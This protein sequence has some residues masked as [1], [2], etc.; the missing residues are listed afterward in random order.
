[1]DSSATSRGGADAMLPGPG[2]T[3]VGKYRVDAVIGQ[4]GMGIVMGG[5]D[6]S[7]GRPVAI[8]FLSPERA[9]RPGAAERFL[10]EARSAAM[11]QSEHV[12]RV[13]EVS[14]LPNGAPFIV[15]EHLRGVDLAQVLIHAGDRFRRVAVAD[16]GDDRCVLLHQDVERRHFRS[17]EVTHPVHMDLRIL[18]D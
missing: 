14:Q 7:L 13:Y 17:S 12:V 5:V 10:R 1:M 2:D 16:R 15:M 3:I 4:G 11:I 9:G 8:K 6:L 18:Q